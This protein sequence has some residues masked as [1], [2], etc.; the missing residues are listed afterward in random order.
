MVE[1]D[2]EEV[3]CPVTVVVVDAGTLP[4]YRTDPE[5]GDS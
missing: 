4:Q 5:R 2:V 1:D 3:L